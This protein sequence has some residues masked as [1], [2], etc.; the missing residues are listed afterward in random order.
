M[1]VWCILSLNWLLSG[2]IF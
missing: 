2:A 1:L